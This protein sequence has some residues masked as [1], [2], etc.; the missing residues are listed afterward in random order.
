MRL[1]QQAKLVMQATGCEVGT[2]LLFRLGCGTASSLNETVRGLPELWVCGAMV[3][4]AHSTKSGKSVGP[5]RARC[6]S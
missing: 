5:D 1:Q 2:E 6:C 4:I 3:K